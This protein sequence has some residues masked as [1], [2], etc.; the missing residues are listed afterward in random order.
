MPIYRLTLCSLIV[1]FS[2]CVSHAQPRNPAR[3]N[4]SERN[5]K[6]IMLAVYNLVDDPTGCEIRH[7]SGTI[8][9]VHHDEEYAT[10]IDGFTLLGA[11]GERDYFNI[12]PDI[13]DDF[14]LPRSDIGWLPTLIA[15]N[16]RV[17]VDAYLCGVSGG[18]ALAHNVISSSTPAKRQR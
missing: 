9:K 6:T 2:F 10:K 4:I 3:A 13:Y 5:R 15:A 17:R 16:N 7:Y 8:I 12:D 14:R 1:A 11:K 18:V